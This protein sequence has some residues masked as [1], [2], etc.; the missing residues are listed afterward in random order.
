[1]QTR[2][3]LPWAEGRIKQ[4]PGPKPRCDG[5]PTHG[6]IGAVSGIE[7]LGAATCGAAASPAFL[8]D[9]LGVLRSR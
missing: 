9:A 2:Q 7:D 5:L 1:M 4:R 6:D 8:E 3:A